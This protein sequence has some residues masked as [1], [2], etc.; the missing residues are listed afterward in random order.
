MMRETQF[1]AWKR[2][3]RLDNTVRPPQQMTF[4]D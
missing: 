4:L 3:Q 1:A 2:R